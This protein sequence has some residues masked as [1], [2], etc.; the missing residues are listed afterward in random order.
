MSWC[1]DLC[2]VVI[3]AGG[4]AA[5]ASFVEAADGGAGAAAVVPAV[6]PAVTGQNAVPVDPVVP[7]AGGAAAGKPAAPPKPLSLLAPLA[8]PPVAPAESYEL[9]RA[10]DGSG[11]LLYRAPGFDARIHPDGRVRFIDRH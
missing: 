5:M 10:D 11:D 8:P 2:R 1:R 3:V 4:V 9:R 6:P 7:P